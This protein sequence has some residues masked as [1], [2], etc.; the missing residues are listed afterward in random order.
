MFSVLLFVCFRPVLRRLRGLIAGKV[1]GKMVSVGN[2]TS[3]TISNPAP[4][5]TC[6]FADVQF[7]L[8]PPSLLVKV[9][10]RFYPPAAAGFS[11]FAERQLVS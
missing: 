11:A 9:I 8:A 6:H 4:G 1:P 3:V 5:C 10:P 7:P 2:A